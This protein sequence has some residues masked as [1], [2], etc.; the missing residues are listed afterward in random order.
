MLTKLAYPSRN[1]CGLASIKTKYSKKA[2]VC[3]AN[4]K[5]RDGVF[6]SLSKKGLFCHCKSPVGLE[7]D[8]TVLS[9]PPSKLLAKFALMS[10]SEC[11]GIRSRY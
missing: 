3:Q 11:W 2:M 10:L 6:P 9:L 5:E 1:S 7:L 8:S 4:A